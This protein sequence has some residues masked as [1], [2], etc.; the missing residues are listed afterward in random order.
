MRTSPTSNP[1]NA[2]QHRPIASTAAS[3]ILLALGAVWILIGLEVGFSLHPAM[4]VS[5][6]ARLIMT[7]AMLA[8]GIGLAWLA[9]WLARPRRSAFYAALALLSASSLSVIF[10]QVGWADLMFVAANVITIILL[11]KARL[12]YLGS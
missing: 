9:L 7:G 4:H 6:P 12:W 5:P 3:I 11:F 10:D 1:G 2:R 8:V